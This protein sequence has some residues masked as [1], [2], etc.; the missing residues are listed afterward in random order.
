MLDYLIPVEN[1]IQ[2]YIHEIGR[3]A[4]QLLNQTG[5]IKFLDSHAITGVCVNQTQTYSLTFVGSAS[6][7]SCH[8]A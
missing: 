1:S 8:G 5:N 7:S 6:E 3:D 2:Q 4:C